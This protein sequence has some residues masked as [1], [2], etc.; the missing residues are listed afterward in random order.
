[1]TH[2]RP[3]LGPGPLDAA[4]ARRD[5]VAISRRQYLADAA[6]LAERLP[7]AGAMLN[8][9][10]DRYLF[11][12]GLGA[13][14]LRGQA[15]LLPPNHT[16]HT[17]ER[18][19]SRFAGTYALVESEG[20]GDGLPEHRPRGDPCR[21]PPTAP[22][23]PTAR[24]RWRRRPCAHLRLDRRSAAACQALGPARRQRPRRGGPPGARRAAATRSKA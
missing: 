1:M 14:V 16:P 18:L 9:S 24:R 13:A 4:I 17:V 8:L 5:G 12:V 3:L 21:R 23:N 11:A 10:V 20:E 2:A 7:P 22:A 19:R 15:C 6:A